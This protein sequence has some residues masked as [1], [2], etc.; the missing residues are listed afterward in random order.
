MDI[1]SV[2]ELF[3]YIKTGRIYMNHASTGPLSLRVLEKINAALKN[4]SEGSI[5]DY[6]TFLRVVE[7]TKKQIADYLNTEPSRIAFGDNT[8][9]GINLI[10]QGIKWKTGDKIILNDLEFPANVYPFLNLQNYGV[11]VDILKSQ[12]GII[13]A[14][15]IINKV[16][17]GTR[18]ISV[19]QVQFLTGYR[20]DLEKLGRFCRENNILL[21][22]DAIQGLGAFP[23]DVVKDN[24]DF[25]SSGTQKWLLGLQGL[26]IIYVSKKLQDILKPKYV[27]WLSV[28]G[29]WDLLNYNL[30][31]KNSADR[32]QTGT[33]NTLGIHALNASM[34][35][36]NDFGVKEVQKR[37][38]ANVLMLMK[39][40][41]HTGFNPLL[42]NCEQKNLSGIVSFRV[43]DSKT[44][45]DKLSGMNINTALR[46]SIIR[47]SPHFYNNEEDIDKIIAAIGSI[48]N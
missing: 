32:Y 25:I 36:F 35:L 19:S 22:V 42:K 16:K 43:D 7:E 37:V 17:P 6:F 33:L 5:D 10:A 38:A 13:S 47:L 9:N 4:S 8:T 21:S 26:S 30:E 29:A 27:G 1:Q 2:R 31:L 46:E 18:L 24:V 23:I 11:E 45:F 3:P 44:F 15:D 14:D 41:E 28:E 39:K 20:I 40:L 34:K 12:D 48:R